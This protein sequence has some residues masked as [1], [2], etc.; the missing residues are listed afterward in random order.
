MIK[1][2]EFSIKDALK[3]GSRLVFSDEILFSFSTYQKKSWDPKGSSLVL[4]EKTLSIV[5]LNS[6]SQIVLTLKKRESEYQEEMNKMWFMRK[7]ERLENL[8]SP[9]YVI[10]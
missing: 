4:D 6:K 5:K 7:P 3:S 9:L 1:R 8:P 2:I 10:N